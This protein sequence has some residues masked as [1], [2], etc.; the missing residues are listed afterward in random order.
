MHKSRLAFAIAL[1]CTWVAL[2]LSTSDLPYSDA[3]LQT[4]FNNPS[5]DVPVIA[6]AGFPFV[7]FYYPPPPMG[8]DIPPDGSFF[9][10][11]L[12][13]MIFFLFVRGILQFIPEKYFTKKLY[14]GS[15]YVAFVITLLGLFITIVKFD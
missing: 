9:P 15:F 10:F 5:L 13:V 12:N 8:N 3:D 11:A 14:Q 2:W 7:V 4:Y 1:V 6:K